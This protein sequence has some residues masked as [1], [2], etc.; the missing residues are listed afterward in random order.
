MILYLCSM[1]QQPILNLITVNPNQCGGKPCVRGMRIRVTDVLELIA[2]GLT[3]QQIIGEL[4]DLT[5]EDVTACIKYAVAKINHPV[6]H[7]A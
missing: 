3:A 6:L 4:P 5:A 2:N 7:A 1:Q